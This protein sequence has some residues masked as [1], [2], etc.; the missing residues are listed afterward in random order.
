MSV[1]EIRKRLLKTNNQHRRSSNPFITDLFKSMDKD[2]SRLIEYH[3]FKSGIEMLGMRNLSELEMK[4]LFDKFDKNKNGKVGFGE[5]VNTLRPPMS[6]A[7]LNVINEA[8]KKL[9]VNKDGVLSIEDFRVLYN[10]QAKAHPKYM[11]GEWT[12]DQVRIVIFKDSF[13]IY[14]FNILGFT[15]FF[16][17]F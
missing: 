12:M 15:K 7:R 4:N 8:F 1:E 17:C 10:V 11:C 5:F 3:E 13:S 9:D 16:G 14:F 6:E 2:H